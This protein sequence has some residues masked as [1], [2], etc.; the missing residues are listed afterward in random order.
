MLSHPLVV[1]SRLPLRALLPSHVRKP[2]Q[3]AACAADLCCGTVPRLRRFCMSVVF[4]AATK[5][6]SA[7]SSPLSC[8]SCRH[9]L[10]VHNIKRRKRAPD[11]PAAPSAALPAATVQRR[12]SSYADAS[13]GDNGGASG[14]G[15]FVEEQR[16]AL[17]FFMPSHSTGLSTRFG[18]CEPSLLMRTV[19][20][21]QQ[22]SAVACSMQ[23]A[24]CSLPCLAALC[25]V[26]NRLCAVLVAPPRTCR[27]T[28]PVVASS[29]A[30][31]TALTRVWTLPRASRRPPQPCAA[32][33]A[34]L[35]CCRRRLRARAFSSTNR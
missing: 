8:R 12:R 31:A 35:D 4:V 1:A 11:Q 20:E 23:V 26:S 28:H 24:E 13:P 14:G 33:R 18:C 27:N 22:L 29:G 6:T 15:N 9:A 25:A 17:L 10:S 3:T 34:C 16:C 2:F 5:L 30:G 19:F 21:F 32:G 7:V